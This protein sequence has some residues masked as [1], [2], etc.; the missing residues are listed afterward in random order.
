MIQ[1]M[2]NTD[3]MVSF[4]CLGV[5][6]SLG[7]PFATWGYVAAVLLSTCCHMLCRALHCRV[8]VHGC[9]QTSCV[10]LRRSQC[11]AISTVPTGAE[12]HVANSLAGP[13]HRESDSGCVT[14]TVT[15]VVTSSVTVSATH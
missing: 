13:G 4:V 8:T 10:V 9:H 2:L 1:R 3:L 11:T 15:T 6:P 14:V 5:P 12:L 7:S